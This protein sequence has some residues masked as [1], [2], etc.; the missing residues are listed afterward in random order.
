MPWTYSPFSSLDHAEQ[1][2]I[3][4]SYEQKFRDFDN[5]IIVNSAL[6]VLEANGITDV[7]AVQVG[8]ER[9][10]E[11][12]DLFSQLIGKVADDKRYTILSLPTFG[13]RHSVGVVIDTENHEC[14]VIDSLNQFYG[15]AV[16]QVQTAID[17]GVLDGYKVITPS[18]SVVQQSDSWSCGIHSAANMVGIITGD[19]NLKD[20]ASISQRNATEVSNLLG[21]FSK[22]YA[23]ISVKRANE[24]DNPRLNARQKKAVRFALEAIDAS[25]YDGT[26]DSDIKALIAAL[27]VE[28]P[29]GLTDAEL[30][31]QRSFTAFLNEFGEKN[32]NNALVPL[33][34]STD[35]AENLPA[36]MQDN[37]EEKEVNIQQY[38]KSRLSAPPVQEEANKETVTEQEE[39]LPA[40][41]NKRSESEAKRKL[42]AF[43]FDKY[44]D[45]IEQK[46]N[47][48]KNS[49]RTDYMSAVTAA[50][51]LHNALTLAK[52]NFIQSQEPPK[53]AWLDFQTACFDA[54]ED[55]REVLEQHRGWKQVLADICSAIVSV[56]TLGIPNIATGRGMF[57]LFRTKTD[58]VEKLDELSNTLEKRVI[59]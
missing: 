47:K 51:K 27:R 58:T 34:T 18:S 11:S 24:L 32:P 48:Y 38:I 1:Q 14:Q 31:Q 59:L 40:V 57:G 12:F 20:N 30:L 28:L 29:S 25:G 6:E 5:D 50:E 26:V 39:V 8:P 54:I 22:A 56:V 36:T 10:G 4:S 44:L 23:D 35:F 45:V 13:G 7:H 37:I 49:T 15:E 55:S 43:D 16:D 3:A 41:E 42:Q 53:T 21:I 9:A 2:R 19:I 17:M 33:L 46:K 52:A